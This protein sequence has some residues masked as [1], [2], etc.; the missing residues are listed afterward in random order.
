LN[1]CEHRSAE[2]S[3]FA[4]HQKQFLKKSK[5]LIQN[6]QLESDSAIYLRANGLRKLTE[7]EHTR[8]F[9]HRIAE[10]SKLDGQDGSFELG[11]NHEWVSMG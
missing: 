4:A 1:A 10:K 6:S 11:S 3:P 8:V 5:S 2:K 9:E 7:A